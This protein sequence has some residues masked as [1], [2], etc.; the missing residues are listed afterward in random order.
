MRD[1]GNLYAYKWFP[2]L[3]RRN[4]MAIFFFFLTRLRVKYYVLKLLQKKKLKKG[5][6]N[7]NYT[8]RGTLVVFVIVT[9][10]STL[11]RYTT[12]ARVRVKIR[13]LGTLFFPVYECTGMR[14]TGGKPKKRKTFKRTSVLYR[15]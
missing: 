1:D 8:G 10:G 15:T 5:D 2:R 14:A 9:L 4:D 6:Y 13:S 7:N 3:C 12:S 11:K